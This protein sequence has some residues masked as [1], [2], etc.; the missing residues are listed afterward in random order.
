MR[1]M[2]KYFWSKEPSKEASKADE[3]QEHKKKAPMYRHAI[4]FTLS[5][6]S[7]NNDT[8][9]TNLKESLP[10]TVIEN[11]NAEYGGEIANNLWAKLTSYEC[12]DA[13]GTLNLFITFETVYK[14]DKNNRIQSDRTLTFPCNRID[15][16]E[17]LKI[18]SSPLAILDR[19]AENFETQDQ[20]K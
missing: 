19:R 8:S 7:L 2:W 9:T 14:K 18:I 16:E 15:Y 12:F 4:S 3:V 11:D 20:S 13:E 10:Q 5:Y 6:Q 17:I 1:A